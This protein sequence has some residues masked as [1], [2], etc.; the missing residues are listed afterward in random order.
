M[1]MV[2]VTTR[3]IAATRHRGG[4]R[5]IIVIVFI[6]VVFL[7]IKRF[8]LWSSIVVARGVL[9]RLGVAGI[10]LRLLV[11]FLALPA[12]HPSLFKESTFLRQTFAFF[13]ILDLIL[14]YQ[15]FRWSTE[16]V[17]VL[18]ELAD[19]CGVRRVVEVLIFLFDTAFPCCV[20]V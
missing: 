19:P 3:M 1:M 5:G 18:T 12:L 8:V 2:M 17:F 20:G 6:V 13:P 11:H 14:T 15:C 4:S 10:V 7:T 16:N 9:L